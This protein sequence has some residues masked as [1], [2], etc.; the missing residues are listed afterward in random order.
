MAGI[1]QCSLAEASLVRIA[2][3]AVHAGTLVATG[4]LVALGV[5]AA[6]VVRTASFQG[7]AL[8]RRIAEEVR[9]AGALRLAVHHPALG[10]G[11]A[12]SVFQTR[13]AALAVVAAFV[14]VTIGVHAALELHALL[15]G[16]TLVSI[17]A[18]AEHA[19]LRHSTQGVPTAGLVVGTGICALAAHAALV[20]GTVSVGLATGDAGSPFAQLTHCAL[21]LGSA[22]VAALTPSALLSAG[23]ILV[24]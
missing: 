22:L 20:G 4:Y 3:A 1:H 6:R 19:V 17:R 15:G 16:L 5:H 23:A 14:G 2:N 7:L 11:A 9:R 13:I 10:I 24:P 21:A 18:V 12:G 8:A